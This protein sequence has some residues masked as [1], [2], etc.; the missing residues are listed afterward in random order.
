M[1]P[2]P[3][4]SVILGLYERGMTA[5]P[6][7]RAALLA[8]VGGSD[9]DATLGDADR[10]AWRFLRARLGP[11]QDAVLTCAQ[12]GEEVEF[13]L[14]A[15]FAPPE[16]AA[17]KVTVDWNGNGV[18]LRLPRL[19]DLRAGGLRP[20]TLAPDADWSDPG[21]RACAEDALLRADPALQLDLNL[22]CAA[23]GADQ[24]HTFDVTGF[25]WARLE[26]AARALV[27]EVAKLARHYGWSEAE[28][29]A[30]SLARR[31]I[32]LREIET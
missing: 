19:S 4:G 27:R 18:D 31:A 24:T 32:Y 6:V 17:D 22:T 11:A 3:T 26:Q 25:V 15:E 5:S 20:E 21:F 14:P 23:C 7:D 9:A 1:A 13:T 28:I 2:D 29:T 12:C 16:A 8:Q 10:A 30:M